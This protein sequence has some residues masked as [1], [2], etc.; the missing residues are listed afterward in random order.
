[1]R[2]VGL[3][4]IAIAFSLAA[5]LIGRWWVPILAL[6]TWLGLAIFLLANDGWHG[7]GWGE[8]GVFWNVLVAIL[9]VSG[10]VIGVATNHLARDLYRH[11]SNA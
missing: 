2:H 6:A 8:F 1:M 5:L 3:L 10:S 4:L 7:A 9:T 11:S